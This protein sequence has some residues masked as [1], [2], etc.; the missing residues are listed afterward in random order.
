MAERYLIDTSAVIKYLN[1]TLSSNGLSFLDKIVDDQSIISFIVEIEL[2]S[3]NPQNEDDLNVYK[4]FILNSTIIGI[5]NDIIQET[6]KIRKSFRLKLPDAIIAA[7]A[8]INDLILVSDN[9]K[10]FK[11]I[12][13]LKYINANYSQ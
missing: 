13:N 4:V 12:S 11:N 7:T 3:W 5:N 9:D 10:D 6:I 8:I 2:Q 1:E